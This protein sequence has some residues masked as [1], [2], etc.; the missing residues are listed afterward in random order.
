MIIFGKKAKGDSILIFFMLSLLMI[1]S[2]SLS[3]K[4]TMDT[5]STDDTISSYY[6]DVGFCSCDRYASACDPLCCCDPLC[7][8]VR[9]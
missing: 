7:L 4:M 1:Q 6:S 5:T 8:T 3:I 2:Q 9:I